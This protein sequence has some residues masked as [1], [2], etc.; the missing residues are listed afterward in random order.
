MTVIA[1]ERNHTTRLHGPIA[2]GNRLRVLRRRSATLHQMTLTRDQRILVHQVHPAK[3]AV[4]IS[5]AVV[6]NILLWKHRLPA[7]L[8]ARYLPPVVG[9]A[10]VLKF[11]D[12]DRLAGTSAGRY[13]LEHMP[14]VMVAVRLA[15]DTLMAVRA[16]RRQ[17]EYVVLATLLVILGWSH[18][19]IESIVR[20]VR[21]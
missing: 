2:L 10:L 4:D 16:W 13:V 9:S 21:R 12:V 15:G 7:G 11:A 17:P 20:G 19:V 5:A 14:P 1:F 18:G 3:L 6:S 8:A